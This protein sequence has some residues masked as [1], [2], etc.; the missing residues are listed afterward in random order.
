MWVPPLCS[1]VS[2]DRPLPKSNVSSNPTLIWLEVKWGSNWE[3]K[4][5]K[6]SR[7]LGS[8]GH[9]E[10]GSFDDENGWSIPLGHSSRFLNDQVFNLGLPAS[11]WYASCTNHRCKWPKLQNCQYVELELCCCTYS[12]WEL[13]QQIALYRINQVQEFPLLN[14]IITFARAHSYYL[15]KD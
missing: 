7:L 11:W 1:Q 8:V 2:F 14:E 6:K 10:N 13:I 12:D 3:Y 5:S 4:L 15:W 9:K